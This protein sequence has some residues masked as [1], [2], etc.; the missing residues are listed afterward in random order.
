MIRMSFLR[1]RQCKFFVPCGIVVLLVA[2]LS[3]RALARPS[4]ATE[5]PWTS[6]QTVLPATLAAELKEARKSSPLVIYV[7][8]RV[9]YDGAHIPGAVF[10]GPGSTT[11]GIANL[12]AYVKDLPRDSNIVLYCGCCPLEKCPNIRPAFR[13][14]R[15][16]GF[17]KLRVLL[18]PTSFAVDWVGRGYPVQKG[19]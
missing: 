10:H 16:M 18:L 14:L 15:E 19:G 17:A 12:K 8:V 6:A 1:I 3:G 13:A 9:L 5:E 4:A 7:G 2:T 11:E